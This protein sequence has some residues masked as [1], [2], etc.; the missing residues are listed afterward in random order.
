[1]YNARF[2]L[3]DAIGKTPLHYAVEYGNAR[4]LQWFFHVGAGIQ[5]KSKDVEALLHLNAGKR[6]RDLL[7][8]EV[9]VLDA[10]NYRIQSDQLDDED[11]EGGG[12]TGGTKDDTDLGGAEL[13][14]SVFLAAKME[15]D[16]ASLS[17]PL[18]QSPLL[19]A[20][21]FGNCSA[22]ELLLA[23]GADA[24]AR[25]ANGWTA[26]HVRVSSHL[27]RSFSL[28]HRLILCVVLRQ[29]SVSGSSQAR[30][31]SIARGVQAS[32]C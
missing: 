5:L 15:R 27:T 9:E 2:A 12:N 17:G 20:A 1:M 24:G 26:L 6:I 18:L 30:S 19:K 14:V 3:I 13:G 22:V 11:E 25:D 21:M 4:Q 7:L 23:K 31:V 16:V 29:R 10:V 28:A 32:E 8:R